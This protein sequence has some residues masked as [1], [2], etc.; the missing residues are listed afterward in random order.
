MG[1][2]LS[3]RLTINSYLQ[4]LNVFH[5]HELMTKHTRE[6][7]SCVSTQVISSTYA[8]NKFWW[9]IQKELF[10]N[11]C[12]SIAIIQRQS[13]QLA[14]QNG[15]KIFEANSTIH[16]QKTLQKPV[17]LYKIWQALRE[18]KA[19]L[20]GSMK[21]THCLQK[22]FCAPKFTGFRTH[23]RSAILAGYEMTKKLLWA[24]E[25]RKCST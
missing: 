4:P 18:I 7:P 2:C 19:R 16:S 12:Q 14:I 23:W 25:T 21:F 17:L 20:T 22:V 8:G 15:L 11:S 1:V 24:L 6:Y 9:Q 5:K 3:L 10:W 13:I